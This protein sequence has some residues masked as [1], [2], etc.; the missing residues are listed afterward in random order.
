[1]K[2]RLMLAALILAAPAIPGCGARTEVDAVAGRTVAYRCGDLSISANFHTHGGVELGLGETRLSLPQAVAASGARYAD[3]L[4]N[5][6]WTQGTTARFT[7][8]G[9][10]SRD[11][12]EVA[13]G[14]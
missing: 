10:P 14:A 2:A 3:D 5:E 6:F 8:A 1:M 13:G 7:Q 9:Q 4:G 11:C 12:S